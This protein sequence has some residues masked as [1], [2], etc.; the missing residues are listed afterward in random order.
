MLGHR[1][2]DIPAK[3]SSLAMEKNFQVRGY[4]IGAAEEQTRPPRLVRVAVVQNAIVRSTSD[5][6]K[7]QVRIGCNRTVK[8]VVLAFHMVMHNCSAATG[9]N[10]VLW[11]IQLLSFLWIQYLMTIYLKKLQGDI[12]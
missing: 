12:L 7:D 9:V 5:P 2:L 4:M 6:V 10:V 3:A 1:P 8:E 11:Y